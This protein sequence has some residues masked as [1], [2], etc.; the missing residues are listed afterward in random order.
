ME[1]NLKTITLDRHY[2]VRE[3]FWLRRAYNDD[4]GAHDDEGTAA[5]RKLKIVQSRRFLYTRRYDVNN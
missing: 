1:Y 2:Y 4:C 5:R 3:L